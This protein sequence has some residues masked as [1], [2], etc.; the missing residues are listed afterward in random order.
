MVF[1]GYAVL[2][3]IKLCLSLI[4]SSACEAENN[5]KKPHRTRDLSET[6]H[7]LSGYSKNGERRKSWLGIRTNKE[8]IIILGKVSFLQALEAIAYGLVV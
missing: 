2:G 5:S 8:S 4:L 3:F 7:L 6:S 1:W